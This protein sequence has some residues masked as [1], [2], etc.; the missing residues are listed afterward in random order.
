AAKAIGERLEA[1]GK[2]NRRLAGRVVCLL[3]AAGHQEAPGFTKLL[4]EGALAEPEAQEEALGHLRRLLDDPETVT[5]ARKALAGGLKS[6][7]GGVVWGAVRC[8]WDIGVRG[9]P[10]LPG[11][12]VGLLRQ[13]EPRASQAGAWLA[14]LL[15]NPWTRVAAVAAAEKAIAEALEEERRDRARGY[16]GGQQALERAWQIGRLLVPIPDCRSEAVIDATIFGGLAEGGRQ[17]QVLGILAGL[18]REGPEAAGRL[19]AGLW[20]AIE[21]GPVEAGWGAIRALREWFGE[22]FE[23]AVGQTDSEANERSAAACRVLLSKSLSGER[24]A[25]ELLESLARADSTGKSVRGA[26]A[27]LARD[28]SD[29]WAFY[30]ASW[31]IDLEFADAT[32]PSAIVKGLGHWELREKAEEM[33]ERLWNHPLLGPSIR[34]AL[35]RETW[36]GDSGSA[37]RAALTL[38]DHGVA[39]DAGIARGLAMGVSGERGRRADTLRRMRRLLADPATRDVGIETLRVELLGEHPGERFAVAALL[40]KAGAHLDVSLLRELGSEGGEHWPHATLAALAVSGR[41]AEARE[42]AGRQGFTELVRLL[43][44]GP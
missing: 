25:G 17:D 30:A 10:E 21:K 41:V 36:A 20:R 37:S 7:D 22:E 26:L 44:S 8:L 43:G 42:A 1:V 39:A 15:Q 23:D 27:E 33:I 2:E 6:G 19:E 11:A 32:M 9:D 24:N 29:S 34:Y 12:L 14:E 28:K 16:S 31:A 4:V 18:V 40:V 38:L 5:E 35:R 13:G 3:A